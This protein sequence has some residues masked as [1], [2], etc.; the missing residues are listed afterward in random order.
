[1]IRTTTNVKDFFT[2]SCVWKAYE[3]F[4]S[5]G[6]VLGFL[7]LMP[8]K[9]ATIN[10]NSISS[11]QSAIN[12]ASPG[13]QIVMA[14]GTYT[15]SGAISITRQGTASQ[16][17]TITAQSIGGVEIKGTSGFQVNSPA[18][19]IIIKGFKFTHS[20]G[21]A[22]IAS[23]ANHNTFTRNIFQCAAAGTGN[24]PYLSVSGHDC[25]ISYNT[26]QNK[27]TEG[28]MLTIQGPGSSDMAQRTWIHHNYFNNFMP[29]GANNSS[30]IQLGL[31]SRSLA[32]AYTIVEYNLFVQVRGENEG[33]VA[34]KSSD[35]TYRYNT[36][37]SGST[38]L[39]LRH[40]N[41][42]QVYGNFFMGSQGLRFCADDHKIYSNYFEG[43]T[44]AIN[45][46]NGDGEV[47]TGS[48]LTC[49]DRP[50]RVQIV[51]N[52]L[53]NNTDNYKMPGRTGGLGATYI[54][55]ANNILQGGNSVSIS[56]IYSNPTW[57]GNILY[58]TSGGAMPSSGYRTVN[59]LMSEDGNS[60]YHIQSGSPARG[61]S[62]GTYSFVTLDI[63]GQTRGSSR[64]VGAD[65]YSTSGVVNRPLT[66]SMVGHNAGG[67]SGTVTNLALNKSV[68]ASSSDTNVPANAVDGSTGTRWSASGY[69][70]W[71][72]VD[73][74][75]VYNISK[76]EVVCYA[77]R[78]YQYKVEAKATS[79][80]TYTQVVN[81]TTNT[82][83]GTI[84]APLVN[85][86][87]AMSARYVRITVTGCYNYTGTWASLLEF[88]VFGD[89]STAK[90]AKT[91]AKDV[92]KDIA[93][94]PNPVKDYAKIHF[95]VPKASKVSIE[96]ISTLGKSCRV[97]ESKYYEA[98]DYSVDFDASDLAGGT[99]IVRM[100]AGEVTKSV[101]IS[102]VK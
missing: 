72:E 99:Y 63:D 94:W 8:L 81:R 48:A 77:D 60:V 65:Q 92:V 43:C 6:L 75:A 97:I 66:T 3:R 10:V 15:T 33:V 37:G 101:L 21:T 93:V 52:T 100:N 11:L 98:G 22:R 86:F 46:V 73:L 47:A 89:A 58:N 62:T 68:S 16:P 102:I 26:F 69:P 42:M 95:S 91:P 55:F 90:A 23:G 40:G 78:A 50:D 59:P 83:P 18:A 34:N 36:I 74:G 2:R 1:M 12:N 64:D 20:T 35:N 14:N 84:A 67:G 45:C 51:F 57:S 25:E 76:T 88:R 4:F 70:Q 85:T 49:H 28:C 80:G 30:A 79:S 7:A 13:D 39:S 56:G 27:S 29:S 54:T 53:V 24:K 17:I 44:S 96:L 32:S 41:R 71:L 19:Y 87:T 31:S 61:T 9:A 5:L 82:T 38:E